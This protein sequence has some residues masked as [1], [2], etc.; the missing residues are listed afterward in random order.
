M[1]KVSYKNHQRELLS[2]QLDFCMWLNFDIKKP[3]QFHLFYGFLSS[4]G[5]QTKILHFENDLATLQ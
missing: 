5:I 4:E 1:V 2:Y 3:F